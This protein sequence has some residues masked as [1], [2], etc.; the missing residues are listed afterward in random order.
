MLVGIK[1]E[2]NL[3]LELVDIKCLLLSMKIIIIGGL[4]KNALQVYLISIIK[5]ELHSSIL[6]VAMHP[7]GMVVAIGCAD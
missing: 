6:S 2:E 7:S 4:E 5:I 1:L 3:Q